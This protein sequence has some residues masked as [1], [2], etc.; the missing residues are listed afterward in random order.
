[1]SVN[2]V[3]LIGRLTSDP[4]VTVKE[5]GKT[6]CKWTLAVDRFKKGEC[7]FIPCVTFD[8]TAELVGNYC[9]KGNRLYVEGSL[10]IRKYQDKYYTT[11]EVRRIEFLESN[12]E[13]A[14]EPNSD[15]SAL[16]K[17]EPIASKTFDKEVPF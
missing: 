7:D 2:N 14:K 16:G 3:I 8:K 4:E 9:G 6:V 13:Q 12:K 17:S 1:M 11:V 15:F 10:R 5:T